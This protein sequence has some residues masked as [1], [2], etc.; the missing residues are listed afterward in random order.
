MANVTKKV[1]RSIKDNYQAWDTGID[2]NDSSTTIT[3][4]DIFRIE[5]SLYRPG[6]AMILTTGSGGSVS[7]RLNPVITVYNRRNPG[8]FGPWSERYDVVSSG[9]EFTDTSQGP[10]VVP[11]STKY[12]LPRGTVPIKTIQMVTVSGNFKLEVY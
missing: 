12:E 2:T 10:I 6:K 9:H 7:F 4:G 1:N 8:E 11:A 3:T 5:D